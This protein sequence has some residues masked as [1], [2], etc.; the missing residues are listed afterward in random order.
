VQDATLAGFGIGPVL[1]LTVWSELRDGRLVE[2]LPGVLPPNG[3]FW[4]LYPAGR[5]MSAAAEALL[6]HLVA[7]APALV[8]N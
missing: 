3:E 2:V 4:A 1:E 5:K 7:T 6:D 8:P